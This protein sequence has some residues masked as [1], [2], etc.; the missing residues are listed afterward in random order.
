M[1]L[2]SDEIGVVK[3]CCG[4]GFCCL[5]AKCAAGARLYPS[6]K[7][8]PAL[9]WSNESN[10]YYCDLAT[11]SGPVGSAYRQE[12]HIGAGCCSNLNSWRKDVKNRHPVDKVEVPLT[13]D[14]MF[15]LFLNCLGREWM[16]GDATFL[17]LSSF[18]F[19][20][21]NHMN[22]SEDDAAKVGNLVKHYIQENKFEFVKEFMG[23]D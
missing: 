20:L 17:L 23:G 21:I 15:Q 10:R 19:C 1:I 6:A 5:Q 3:E 2:T 11:I 12:L 4:C 14:P 16:S 18:V 8:C 7:V 22:M 13:I 9:I